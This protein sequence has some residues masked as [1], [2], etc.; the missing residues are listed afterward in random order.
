MAG[1]NIVPSIFF[2]LGRVF[3]RLS[4]LKVRALSVKMGHQSA[5]PRT[6][7]KI[8]SVNK[9]EKFFHD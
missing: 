5:Y 8:T 2:L 9:D 3:F 4:T 1:K 6:D 7:T